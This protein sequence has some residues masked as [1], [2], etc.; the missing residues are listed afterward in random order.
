MYLQNMVAAVLFM[1]AKDWS[2]KN[3][4]THTKE[5]FSAIRKEEGNTRGQEELIP[6]CKKT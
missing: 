6:S 4:Y 3:W 1:E 2:D 5:H